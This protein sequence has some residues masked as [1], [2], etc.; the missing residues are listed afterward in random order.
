LQ[1]INRCYKNKQKM[2]NDK[3]IYKY[4]NNTKTMWKIIKKEIRET[5]VKTILNPQ[6][7]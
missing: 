4:E 3:L 2:Y 7:N 5:T 6:K 1:D